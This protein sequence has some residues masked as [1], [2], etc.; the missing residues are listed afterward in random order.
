MESGGVAPHIL[1]IGIRLGKLLVSRLGRFTPE[2]GTPLTDG[3]EAGSGCSS[4]EKCADLRGLNLGFTACSLVTILKY[5]RTNFYIY[6]L[7]FIVAIDSR[8]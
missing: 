8:I 7:I 4:E 3:Q 6:Q 1:N 5:P 2:E